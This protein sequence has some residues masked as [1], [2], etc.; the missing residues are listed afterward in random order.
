VT[1]LRRVLVTG[2]AGQVGREVVERFGRSGAWDVVAASHIDL[3]LEDRDNVLSAITALRPA[4]IVHGG[5]W[6]AVDECESHPRRAFAVNALGTR[7]VADGARRVGAHV[8]YLSTD[9]VFDGTKHGPYLE[10]DGPNPRSVYGR[11]K[12]GGE[13]EID[14]GWT[15]ARTSWVCGRHGH[16]MVKTILRLA[17]Q[18]GDL[19]F[20]DDQWGNP[21]LAD[22]L[23]GALYDLAVRRLPGIYH[24]TNQGAVSW[25]EFARAVLEAAGE[26][27]DRVTPIATVE[28]DPP[29]PA[30]RPTNSVLENFALVRAGLIP[31][32]D[33]RESLARLVAALQSG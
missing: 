5:A 21:T 20:V 22:D 17:A 31:L 11:S 10:W 7:W 28:L 9:Y 14:P 6:T 13:Q 26:S 12:L 18:P 3:D 19:R 15:I 25:Y 29:R 23:A 1:A 30:P 27:P 2:A 8:V 4:V 32:N 16:N 33:F 24:V